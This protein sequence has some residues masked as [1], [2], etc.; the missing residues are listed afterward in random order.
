M[1]KLNERNTIENFEYSMDNKKFN[2]DSTENTQ[3][4]ER[5]NT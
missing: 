4:Y 1:K 2:R 5:L 3:I